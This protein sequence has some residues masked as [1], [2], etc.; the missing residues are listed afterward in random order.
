MLR[1]LARRPA[2]EQTLCRV[3]S[4]LLHLGVELPHA[5]IENNGIPRIVVEKEKGLAKQCS[6]VLR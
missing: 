3:L 4:P 6:E 5:F 1:C 2:A